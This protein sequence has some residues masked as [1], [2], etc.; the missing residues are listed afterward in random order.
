MSI[1]P[2]VC[3]S[4]GLLVHCTIGPLDHWTNG[5]LDHRT[6][7]P[8]DHWTIGLLDQLV[9]WSIVE[10]QISKVNKVKLLSE[11]TSGVPPVIFFSIKLKYLKQ[12]SLSQKLHEIL[13]DKQSISCSSKIKSPP[14]TPTITLKRHPPKKSIGKW[15][16]SFSVNH[17]SPLFW[18]F[19]DPKFS[20]LY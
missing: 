9:H 11:R 14:L 4:I 12:S 3:W 8:L 13:F 20:K 18:I 19:H 10:C 7:G 2:L 15:N 17:L 6:I 5:P 16:F 1:G